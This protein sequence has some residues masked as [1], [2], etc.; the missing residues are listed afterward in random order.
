MLEKAKAEKGAVT[1]KAGVVVVPLV[2]GH[3]QFPTSASNVKVHYTGMLMDG[4]VFD[5]SVKRGEPATF[6][7]KQV[8]GMESEEGM[9]FRPY[10]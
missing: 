3:G 2:K 6:A 1:T 7:L 10:S 5:S 9:E 8:R 4:T